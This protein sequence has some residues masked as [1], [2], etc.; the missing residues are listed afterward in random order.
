MDGLLAEARAALAIA[1]KEI[2]VELRY[3]LNAVNQVLQPLYQFLIPSMLLGA[4]F[5]VGGRAIGFE[6]SSGTDNL[7]GFLFLGAF[8]A[9]LVGAAFWGIA[10]SFKVEMDAGTLEPAWLTPT[11]VRTFV[12][13]RALAHFAVAVVSGA[14]L[15]AIGAVLFGGEVALSV[16]GAL[17]ALGVA[18][19][20]LL[21]VGYLVG[22]AVLRMRDPNLMVDATDFLFAVAS[23][24][25]F[26]ILILPEPIRYV[27]LALPTTHALDL[28][29]V[30]ALGTRPL[31]PQ[32]VAWVALVALSVAWLVIGRVAFERTDRVLR[33]RGTLSQH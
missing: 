28:I 5:A 11:H 13:G 3:P 9:L 16:A 4:T 21:G 32:P 29:R 18:A 15:V 33:V 30:H 14:I 31:L 6:E 20:G 26:P 8:V 7:A 25:A 1:R 12:V 19:V 22:A 24:I 17:P 27:A 2:R 23:G 10:Y